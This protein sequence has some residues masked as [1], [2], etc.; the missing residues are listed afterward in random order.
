MFTGITIAYG[1]QTG[2][3]EWISS[4]IAH[5]ASSRGFAA[6]TMTLDEFVALDDKRLDD[7]LVFVT[8]TTGDGDPP[9][10]STK[11]WRW[12]RR[13]KKQDLE[14]FQ[15]RKYALLG[16]GDTNYTN[17]CNSAKRLD[18]KLADLGCIPVCP[19]GLADDGTGLEIVIE[20][21]IDNL[22]EILACQ[23]TNPGQ[24]RC[25]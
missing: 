11:F 2:N 9:D 21:W 5:Q 23:I 22:F 3:A 10:N 24:S 18:R 8:S 25:L 14:D 1:S 15:G 4:H 6:S 20:P 17:F 19:K 12:F 7:L 13:A 16:L